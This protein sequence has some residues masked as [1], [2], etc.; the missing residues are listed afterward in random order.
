M[1]GIQI[2]F[3]L[4]MVGLAICLGG[5]F[6]IIKKSPAEYPYSIILPSLIGGALVSFILGALSFSN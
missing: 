4:C 6:G 2:G 1:F 5:M 3:G